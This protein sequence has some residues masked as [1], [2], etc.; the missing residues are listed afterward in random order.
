MNVKG[1]ISNF[2]LP[3]SDINNT[4]GSI[5]FEEKKLKTNTGRHEKDNLI[6]YDDI[7]FL[8]DEGTASSHQRSEHVIE[9]SYD[10]DFLWKKKADQSNP[11]ND[12]LIGIQFTSS[13]IEPP[14]T[15]HSDN[16]DVDV[17][18]ELITNPERADLGTTCKG[19][20]IRQ[21]SGREL[22]LYG[23]FMFFATPEMQKNDMSLKCTIQDRESLG[24]CYGVFEFTV[25]LIRL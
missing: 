17:D 11:L 14:P 13:T 12:L 24:Y 9:T 23:S 7:S 21:K 6:S 8:F 16:Y 5:F 4:E 22:R 10:N 25:D 2:Y 18:L 15:N 20:A 19:V 1:R 3:L